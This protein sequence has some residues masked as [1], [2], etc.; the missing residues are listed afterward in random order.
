MDCDLPTAWS[1]ADMK[2]MEVVA[3]GFDAFELALLA[4]RPIHDDT[5]D[6]DVYNRH[7]VQ[8]KNTLYNRAD[9]SSETPARRIDKIRSVPLPIQSSSSDAF[10]EM[11]TSFG[12]WKGGSST[13][14]D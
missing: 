3:S 4:F 1:R 2:P 7:R 8:A 9:T 10:L 12:G 13:V 5:F 6:P 11:K 14:K